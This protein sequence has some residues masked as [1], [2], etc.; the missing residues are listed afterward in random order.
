MMKIW[1]MLS[2][3]V[4]WYSFQV[5]DIITLWRLTAM[6]YVKGTCTWIILYLI[7]IEPFPSSP[8]AFII[9]GE[10]LS[11]SEGKRKGDLISFSC[12]L[13]FYFFNNIVEQGPKDVLAKI[14]FIAKERLL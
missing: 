10:V 4:I 14:E 9:N 11:S 6:A 8:F 2:Q 5:K 3:G 1:I 7:Q 12:F 13:S